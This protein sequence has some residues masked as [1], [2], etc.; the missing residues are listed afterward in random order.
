MFSTKL[1]ETGLF[2][3]LIEKCDSKPKNLKSK[4]SQYQMSQIEGNCWRTHWIP[5]TKG[6][7]VLLILREGAG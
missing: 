6:V 3:S 5:D 7:T 2:L 1:K 4:D